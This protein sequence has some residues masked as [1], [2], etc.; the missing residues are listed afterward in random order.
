MNSS[1]KRRE[2][3]TPA[4]WTVAKRGTSSPSSSARRARNRRDPS[5]MRETAGSRPAPTRVERF[6][7]RATESFESLQIRIRSKLCQNSGKLSQL[8]RNSE[9]FRTSQ[10]FLECSAKFREK[11]S[12][13]MQNSMKIVEKMRMFEEIRTKFWKS[14]TNC[15]RIFWMRA[16]QRRVNLVDLEKC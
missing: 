11:S 15:L 5:R 9:N 2:E 1:E 14:L 4:V 12:K 16:V 13:L 8:F 7:C 10:Y 6:G 3:T